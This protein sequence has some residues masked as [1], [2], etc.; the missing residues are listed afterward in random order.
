MKDPL[1]SRRVQIVAERRVLNILV[2][3]GIGRSALV[4]PEP[5][6]AMRLS[7]QTSSEP[8]AEGDCCRSSCHRFFELGPTR[9]ERSSIYPDSVQQVESPN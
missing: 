9:R 5:R 7:A 6:A 8:E 3:V 2:A 1:S 4:R